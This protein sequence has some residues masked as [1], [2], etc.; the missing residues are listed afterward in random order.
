MLN[1]HVLFHR[2]TLF[3]YHAPPPSTPNVPNFHYPYPN[4][5]PPSLTF[6]LPRRRTTSPAYGSPPAHD[7]P[8][9]RLFQHKPYSTPPPPTHHVNS[10][11]IYSIHTLY[12][13]DLPPNKTTTSR[14]SPH[15]PHPD[16]PPTHTVHS[17]PSVH[18]PTC[19]SLFTIHSRSARSQSQ[20]RLDDE[21]PF[22]VPSP[23]PVTPTP[24]QTR[25][26]TTMLSPRTSHRSPYPVHHCPPRTRH[27][28][29]APHP[30]R[31]HHRPPMR[32]RQ[33]DPDPLS[34][35]TLLTAPT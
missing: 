28:P 26:H 11:T 2:P 9:T 4:Q 33:L 30:P 14:A 18:D 35:P 5:P 10:R 1:T 15:T 16:N 31:S 8:L 24:P 23:S 20:C 6:A 32:A 34:A 12:P 7:P 13:T 3:D 25:S 27:T 17:S 29:W 19:P 22:L 21:R